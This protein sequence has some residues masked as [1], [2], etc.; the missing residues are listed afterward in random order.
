MC[1]CDQR[2]STQDLF[3]SCF[4][5]PSI[6]KKKNIYIYIRRQTVG[7]EKLKFKTV[8]VE[9]NVFIQIERPLSQN[10]KEKKKITP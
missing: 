9:Y 10:G 4:Y 3:L 5:Y 7:D 6:P 2:P 8:A 1:L